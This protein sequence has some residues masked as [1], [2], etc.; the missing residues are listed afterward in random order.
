MLLQRKTSDVF[1]RNLEVY[2]ASSRANFWDG[3]GSVGVAA[4][5]LERNLQGTTTTAGGIASVAV[6]GVDELML[7]PWSVGHGRSSQPQSNDPYRNEWNSTTVRSQPCLL[8]IIGW[9]AKH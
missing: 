5:D 8:D 3:R 9:I 2:T 1:C 7:R 4:I 6:V